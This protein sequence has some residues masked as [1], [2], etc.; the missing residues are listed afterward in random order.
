MN[1]GELKKAIEAQGVD[2][3]TFVAWIDYRSPA[4]PVVS[5]EANSHYVK[6]YDDDYKSVMGLPIPLDKG[7]TQDADTDKKT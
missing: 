4:K 7:T 1:W 2:D 5:R 3:G 6:I